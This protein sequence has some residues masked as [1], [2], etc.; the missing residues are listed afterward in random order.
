MKNTSIKN[1][2][3]WS[4]TLLV[5]LFVLNGILTI[6]TL[7][8]NKK[9][10]DHIA[11]VIDPSLQAIEDFQDIVS[12]SKMYTT[13]WVFLRSNQED[14]NALENLHAN[15]Y[16][17]LKRKIEILFFQLQDRNVKDSVEYIFTKFEQLLGIENQIMNSLQRFENYDDPVIKL[18][19]ERL[20]EDEILPRT[21]ELMNATNKV[22]AYTQGM[23]ALKNDELQHA[24]FMLRILISVF[25]ITIILIGIFLS[26]YMTRVII[27]PINKIRHIIN[28]LG[29]GITKKID[30]N[31]NKDEIGKMVISVNNL[32]EKLQATAH[33]AHEVGMR[34]FDI[35]FQPLSEEDTLGK[36]LISMRDNLSASEKELL[37]IT[38]DLNKKDKLLQAVGMAT[39]ELISNNNL[40][41]ALG[42]GIRLLGLRMQVDGVA[43]YK[44]D[45][46]DDGA[47]FFD[48]MARW[49]SQKNEI[50]YRLTQFQHIPEV[51]KVSEAFASNKIYQTITC[52]LQDSALKDM[53]MKQ[54]IKS[55]VSLPLYV[56][57]Q[58]WGFVAFNDC[59][60]ERKW[61]DTEF[62]ILQSFAATLGSAIERTQVE[63]QLVVA[64]EKAEA[65]SKAKSEFM[66]NMSHE[67]RTPMNGI[68]GFTDLVLTT[69]LEKTQR[70]YLKNVSKSGYSL[71]NIIND[72]LDFSKI[73]AGKLLIDETNFKLNETVEETVDILSIKAQEKGLELVCSIDPLL[74]SQFK[75]DPVRI[76]QILINLIGNAIKFTEK[77]DIFIN[78]QSG[79][80]YEKNGESCL[81]ISLSVKDTGIGIAPEK[82]KK[83]FESFTQADNSTTRKYGGTGLGLTISRRL[84]ELM[85]GSLEVQSEPGKGSIFTL[86]TTLKIINA[87]PPISFDSK[88]LLREVLVVDDN[89][90]NCKLMRGIFEYLHIPCKICFNGP[91]ALVEIAHSLKKGEMF[92]LIITDHQMPV[93]DGITLVKEIKKLLK[94]HMEPFILMLSSLEKTLYQHEAEKIGINKF[95]NKPVKLQELNGILTAIFRKTTD[96]NNVLDNI[97]KIEKICENSR[98]LVV[99]DDPI[100]MMLITEVLRNM[101]VEVIK[102]GNGKEALEKLSQEDPVLIF[103]DINMPEMDGLTATRHIRAMPTS[104]NQV[105]I[106]ALT[107]DAMKEDKEKCIEVGM[108]DYVSKPFRLE[109][110][111]YILKN[112][113]G[114]NLKGQRA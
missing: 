66:A 101:G 76:R 1:R 95:L 4:F 90:T 69:S 7:N 89:E 12:N 47:V 26:L 103:M 78:V 32:S 106:I 110:I 99:E 30:Y 74:P 65:A 13:N 8:S 16:P 58:F 97:P 40:E 85:G 39:H 53:L 83:I 71:L 38:D 94:G 87:K 67:L 88:P 50:E 21:S 19:A 81:D 61:T 46:V 42:E 17:A 107:A 63:Q 62:S 41:A 93:M 11:I 45:V 5:A 14:K 111:E 35:P 112:Y 20:V 86:G 34:H 36:A 9:S 100:N 72:I 6:I 98:V 25:T 108:N 3:Y 23:R 27:S 104:I 79:I 56:L 33:F 102:A 96:N 109:E 84:A 64:K 18:E 114:N 49:T 57:D 59:K 37:A 113:L 77:G 91:D 48:Q 15:G 2:I 24:S 22:V 51:Q 68:I 105:P 10:S 92:D 75:G 52:E 60:Y 31:A 70:D 44:K 80:A 29:K 55:A 82:L 28:E 73:E 54:Q 43:V